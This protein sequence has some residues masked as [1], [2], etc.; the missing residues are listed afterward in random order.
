MQIALL[1]DGIFILLGFMQSHLT[2]HIAALLFTFQPENYH[3]RKRTRNRTYHYDTYGKNTEEET[4]W[5]ESKNLAH[6]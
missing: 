6:L 5:H 1:N 4:Q 2:R 3:L